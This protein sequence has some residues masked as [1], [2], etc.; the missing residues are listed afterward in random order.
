M[1]TYV[2]NVQIVYFTGTKHEAEAEVQLTAIETHCDWLG[3]KLALH[4][5][6]YMLL[7]KKAAVIDKKVIM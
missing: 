6:F 3:E 2:Q 1:H 5:T 7:A 4:I